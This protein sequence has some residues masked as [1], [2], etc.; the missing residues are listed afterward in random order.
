[1]RRSALAFALSVLLPVAAMAQTAPPKPSEPPKKPMGFRIVTNDP[2]APV[3]RQRRWVTATG[4]ITPDTPQV[5][6][7][8]LKGNDINGLTIYFD[9]AGGSI[10]GAIR[11]GDALRKAGAKVAIGRSSPVGPEPKK[12]DERLP[13]HQLLPG[14]GICFSSCAYAFLGGKTRLIA[15]TA[16]YGVH[17]FWPG[18][19]LEGILSRKYA[20]A[21]IE[22]AQRISANL[23]AYFQ[24][25]GADA[26]VLQIASATPPKGAIRR[27][28]PREILQYRVATLDLSEPALAGTGRWALAL[29]HKDARISGDGQATTPQ[30]TPFNYTLEF[31]CSAA[32]GFVNVRFEMAPRGAAT[33]DKML[34]FNRALL[35]AGQKSGVLA[36][37]G[38]D[39]VAR[40]AAFP[41]RTSASPANWIGASGT[42]PSDVLA[43]AVHNGAAPLNVRIED[44]ETHFIAPLATGNL[45]DAYD[46]WTKACTRIVKNGSV[47]P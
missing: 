10:V 16:A 27:L 41:R 4:A 40:P 35:T 25:V 38:K 1:M 6:E 14:R 47:I 46:D 34:A 45:R 28:T 44:G 31:G 9:S 22:R 21:E 42:I 7:W 20:Y 5:F 13:R 2:D 17:M 15:P 11:L 36:P 29:D 26:T 24:R 30:G 18:D 12:E 39:I 23:A 43:E 32:P 33:P 8:F 3:E 19:Q 37:S